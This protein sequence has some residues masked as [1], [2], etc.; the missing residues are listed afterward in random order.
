MLE[1]NYTEQFLNDSSP[2]IL[3][4]VTA[5]IIEILGGAPVF[6]G[7][8]MVLLIG[9]LGLKSKEAGFVGVVG[10]T[11]AT[12][13]MSQ[14]PENLQTPILIIMGIALVVIIYKVFTKKSS[15]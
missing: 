15:H 4:F 12:I 1:G 9:M 14:M 8:V 13:F 10:F 11:M 2:D 6:Y 5:P 3:G 7:W